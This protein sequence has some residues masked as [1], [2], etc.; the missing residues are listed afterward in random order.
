MFKINQN[1]D[2]SWQ[3]IL[4][5]YIVLIAFIAIW[6]FRQIIFIALLGFI[7]ASLLDKPIEF[8][9]IRLKNRWAATFIIYF[10]FLSGLG[11]IAYFLIPVLNTYIIGFSDFLPSW[12]NKESL[13]QFWQGW[14]VTE[15]SIERWLTLFGVSQGQLYEFLVQSADFLIKILGGAFTAFFVLIFSFFIN[16]E[17]RGIEKAICLIFPRAYEDYVIYLWGKTRQK[18]SSWFFGQLILSTIVGGL[19]F[20]SLKILGI[21][22]AEFLA[23]LAALFDFIPYIGP[24]VI[25]LIAVF[26]G[27]SQNIFL[28]ISILVVFVIVQGIEGFINPLLRA[29]TMKLNPLVILLALL[30]GGRLAGIAG[31]IIALPIAAA[32]FELLRDSRSGRLAS[33]LPQKQLL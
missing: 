13:V 29:K 18:V 27:M 20:I 5:L 8:L 2:I 11:M 25:G 12:M 10:V 26:V 1:I 24:L 30:I 23:V 16:T 14:Q 9:E 15:S 22:Q 32:A 28:G 33:Y 17:K 3:S 4:K 21:A 7:L 31:A 6:Y 19:V